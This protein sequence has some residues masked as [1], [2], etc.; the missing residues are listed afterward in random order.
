MRADGGLRRILIANRGEIALRIIRTCREM[1]IGT[2]AVYA[3]PDA[4]MPHVRAADESVCLGGPA[5]K[6]SYLAMEKL[7]NAAL[8][9]GVDAI[10]PGYGFLSESAVFASRVTKAGL[11]FIGPP[12]E[13]I[14]AMGDKT[15]AR[16]LMEKAG[17]PTIPGST[18]ALRN[19]KEANDFSRMQ[20]FPVL[21]KA[22]AGGGGKGMRVVRG[23]DELP[24]AYTAAREEARTAFGDERIYIE[25]YLEDPRHIEVQIVADRAGN[26]IHLGERECSIQRRH[27]KI[28]EESPSPAVNEEMRCAVTGA[29]LK[30]A[31]I[32]RYES[33]GTVEFL[34]D[35]GG[36]FYFLEMNTRLQ[37]EHTVTEWRSGVD[38]VALQV[39]IA[40]GED[41]PLTQKE[42][43]LT[44][45]AIECRLCAEDV[46]HGFLPAAGR[47][48]H[49]RVPG[50]PGVRDDRGIEAGNE[51]SIHYDSL[52]AKLSV[53]GADR[54]SAVARMIRALGEYEV[55]GVPTNIPLCRSILL[56]PGFQRGDVTTG[57]IE[58][59][60]S[61]GFG[62]DGDS[63]R[64]MAG[65]AVCISLENDA[66]A[67]TGSSPEKGM[68]GARSDWRSRRSD[69]MRQA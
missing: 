33:A 51:V 6:D 41:L 27:Q 39:L 18:G 62:K 19:L 52:L 47:I 57:F 23:P 61:G 65:A 48:L 32:C 13:C 2:V 53:W 16:R 55:L 38:I 66:G 69:G 59:F 64:R 37:V 14:A 4:E 11:L 22:A 26:V 63:W 34:L 25:K 28:I 5:S 7:I 44:G 50:G 42:V 49:L 24:R 3:D 36:K 1:G 30:A 21:L 60:L 56:D 46:L 15:A 29:A 40:Q 31:A 35:R 67:R 20:G 12:P 45:H 43:C 17:I 10:H 54:P 8:R 58:E 68:A 9:A